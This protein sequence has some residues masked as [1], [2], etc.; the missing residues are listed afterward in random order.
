MHF[1]LRILLDSFNF[2]IFCMYKTVC[3]VR[4]YLLYIKYKICTIFYLHLLIIFVYHHHNHMVVN[5]VV[6]IYH[7][8]SIVFYSLFCLSSQE[9][10][11]MEN[12]ESH[13]SLQNEEEEEANRFILPNG[14][15]IR[16]LSLQEILLLPPDWIPVAPRGRPRKGTVEEYLG[17]KNVYKILKTAQ[18]RESSKTPTKAKPIQ[19]NS[20]V[21]SRLKHT[22][23]RE[24]WCTDP[25]Y[26]L[27]TSTRKN[28]C[29]RLVPN[30]LQ[31]T[32]QI[33][34]SYILFTLFLHV[35]MTTFVFSDKF[36][37]LVAYK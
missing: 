27:V 1:L 6:I 18:Y 24:S 13:E 35:I 20:A 34:S 3:H 15:N 32:Y 28:S 23:Y 12:A 37:I 33:V 36:N 10:T 26:I 4:L 5:Y 16:D 21:I 14:Q 7:W 19:T 29:P 25:T 9:V 30:S 8:S 17:K 11:R 2:L 31:S 22:R